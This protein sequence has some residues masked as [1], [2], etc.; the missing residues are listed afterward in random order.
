MRRPRVATVLTA[1][2]WEESFVA[3]ARRTGAVRIVARA[4]RPEEVAASGAEVAVVGEET[5]WLHADVVGLWSALGLKTVLV[6]PNTDSE[7]RV[8]CASADPDDILTTVHEVWL[9]EWPAFD[10]ISIVG[11]SGAGVTEISCALAELWAPVHLVDQDDPAAT[12]RLSPDSR[13]AESVTISPDFPIEPHERTIVDR[14]GRGPLPDGRCVLVVAHTPLSFVRA[15]KLIAQWTGPVPDLV[16]NMVRDDVHARS[17]AVAN[18]GL[19]PLL[20]LPYDP[21]VAARAARGESCPDWF[22][23]RLASLLEPADV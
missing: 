1:L 15:A 16:V 12:L 18:V 17:L 14:G 19:E 20:L 7:Y 11:P 21:E 13:R 22:T 3:H 9:D 10:L 5:G 8:A 6:T 4:Y 23:D 2:R